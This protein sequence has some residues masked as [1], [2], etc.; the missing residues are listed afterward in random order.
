MVSPTSGAG[1]GRVRPPASPR[2]GGDRSGRR[3]QIEGQRRVANDSARHAHARGTLRQRLRHR[4]KNP[5]L[6]KNPFMSIWLS[7]ANK[8]AGAAR[9]KAAAAI[10]REA[11]TPRRTRGRLLRSKCWTSGAPRSAGRRSRKPRGAGSASSSACHSSSASPLGR[12]NDRWRAQPSRSSPQVAGQKWLGGGK[13]E[14]FR[15]PSAPLALRQTRSRTAASWP[16]TWRRQRCGPDLRH[17]RRR[18]D[19]QLCRCLP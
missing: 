7:G 15:L 17:C 2:H 16:S 6:K 13:G 3:C 11:A 4:M 18:Q 5:W 12:A 8:V 14:I 9:G 19:K 10:K 1:D